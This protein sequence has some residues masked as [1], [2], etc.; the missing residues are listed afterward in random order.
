MIVIKDYDRARV[1]EYAHKWAL[2]RNPVFIDYM[3]I[4]GDCTNFISQ[5]VLAGCRHMNYTP[6]FGWYYISN[7]DRAPAWTG[8]PFFYNFIIANKGVGPFAVDAKAA[9]MEIGDIIQLGRRDGTFYHTLAVT[10]S[11]RR[12]L[13][14]STHT[15]DSLDRPLNTYSYQR[16]R[17][18][19]ILGARMETQEVDSYKEMLDGIVPAAAETQPVIDP[20]P[21]V[22]PSEEIP[23]EERR[24]FE[25]N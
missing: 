12:S 22:E 23:E 15:D 4:G 11:G 18:I 14:V 25:M 3:G 13:L 17:Y 6:T 9:D 5:C 8:V 7:T 10:G 21:E 19:H 20:E 1:L 16:I 2:S 24:G